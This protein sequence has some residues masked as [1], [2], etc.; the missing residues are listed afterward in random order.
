MS[1]ASPR[2]ASP[3]Q[4]LFWKEVKQLSLFFVAMLVLGSVLQLLIAGYLTGLESS[5]I[6]NREFLSVALIGGFAALFATAAGATLFATEKEERTIRILQMLPVSPMQ[7][8]RGKLAGA[9]LLSVLFLILATV[10]AM[11]SFRIVAGSNGGPWFMPFMLTFGL[12]TIEFFIWGWLC[13]VL[14][15]QPLNAA[16]FSIIGASFGIQLAIFWLGRGHL[17]YMTFEPYAEAWHFRVFLVAV[18][19]INAL[20]YSRTWLFS[21]EQ[22]S[23][24]S[25]EGHTFTS[26]LAIPFTAIRRRFGTTI[27]RLS[28]LT[29]QSWR[30]SGKGVAIAFTAAVLFGIV[31]SVINPSLMFFTVAIV[32]A[33]GGFAGLAAFSADQN[34]SS[35]H[36][37]A[38]RGVSAGQIW[39]SRVTPWIGL[40]GAVFAFLFVVGLIVL[41]SFPE[42]KPVSQ[43]WSFAYPGFDGLPVK[44]ML[45]ASAS[46]MLIQVTGC[47]AL[48]CLLCFAGGQFI[49][50]IIKSRILALVAT[51]FVSLP[52]VYWVA[53][54]VCGGIPLWWSVLIPMVAFLVGGRMSMKA[55]LSEAGFVRKTVVPSTF[56]LVVLASVVAGV[57]WK[58]ASEIPKVIV[59]FQRPSDPDPAITEGINRRFQEAL[60]MVR[61]PPDL[62][63]N[64]VYYYP[65]LQARTEFERGEIK[66]SEFWRR[67]SFHYGDGVATDSTL[68]KLLKEKGFSHEQMLE[69]ANRFVELNQQT[70][71]ELYQ[72]IDYAWQHQVELEKFEPGSYM[73]AGGK[74][75]LPR[76][77]TVN[78]LLNVTFSHAMQ[79]KDAEAAWK[80]LRAST[81]FEK[82]RAIG[83]PEREHWYA[84]LIDRYER[85]T[86]CGN[87]KPELLQEAQEFV[88]NHLVS[89]DQ[90][91]ILEFQYRLTLE[92]SDASRA[93]TRSSRALELQFNA[94]NQA[95][96]LLRSL[97]FEQQRSRRLIDNHCAMKLLQLR[98]QFP[99]QK[100]IWS[101]FNEISNRFLDEDDVNGVSLGQWEETRY[102]FW[103]RTTLLPKLDHD[104]AY[105]EELSLSY[106]NPDSNAPD[107]DF[108]YKE[109]RGLLALQIALVWHKLENGSYPE[110][111]EGFAF[112]IPPGDTGQYSSRDRRWVADGFS[113]RGFHYFP[114][115]VSELAM[116]QVGWG[117]RYL[118][119][120]TPFISNHSPAI[121][122]RGFEY[123]TRQTY[124]VPP[125]VLPLEIP[126][127]EETADEQ[128]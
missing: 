49:S 30:E 104:E 84:R 102:N 57:A 122:D 20:R 48:A 128:E 31:L 27:P 8:A 76:F 110:T 17:D 82:L 107:F 105:F 81:Q 67:I 42:L 99:L 69:F 115:G 7:I 97:P 37:L 16:M 90:K 29:W 111:L 62:L 60:A 68:E 88:L 78:E 96:R 43:F 61:R 124:E 10:I 39:I 89:I 15:R 53:L 83:L 32:M 71:R 113:T 98:K 13:S 51:A 4:A 12:A 23:R 59:D 91:R 94:I 5:V 120:N 14:S 33:A 74:F 109:R 95:V 108:Y 70:L 36:F 63:D 1:I 87:Q 22:P 52:L 114:N 100:T 3:F 44:E 35:G 9:V 41:S 119:P 86:L 121:V 80:C 26:A 54:I 21:A 40:I 34:R 85:W 47:A 46:F 103:K 58:R 79:K 50:L 126:R 6:R 72:A 106:R 123:A 19:L 56:V 28:R 75:P 45:A 116:T 93:S 125:M 73:S 117:G 127:E 101:S 55:L 38:N 25:D 2:P 24:D 18:V 64:I 112:L 92:K 65:L 118:P 77:P 11:I 66:L